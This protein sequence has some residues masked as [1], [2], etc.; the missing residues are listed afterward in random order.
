VALVAL[1]TV[2]SAYGFGLTQGKRIERGKQA[3]RESLVEAVKDAA[4]QSAATAIASIRVEN[5][6]IRQELEREIRT[7]I[8][9]S[10]CRNSPD[11]L[12]AIND[13]LRAEPA[14]GS[15]LPDADTTD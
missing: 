10:Q 7:V 1:L 13:A 3:D 6:T 12:R 14:R 2:I 11:G 15:K 8:D 4:I 5:T 9:Y